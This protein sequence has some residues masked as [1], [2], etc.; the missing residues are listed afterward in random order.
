M[1]N[2]SACCCTADGW[3]VVCLLLALHL[4]TSAQ[5]FTYPKQMD[6]VYV[7]LE[8]TRIAFDAR[9]SLHNPVRFPFPTK[10]LTFADQ[11]QPKM[12]YS[13]PKGGTRNGVASGAVMGFFTGLAV[14]LILENRS[15][16]CHSIYCPRVAPGS[17]GFAL[18]ILGTLP[19]AIVG[20]IIGTRLRN[21]KVGD[22]SFR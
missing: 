4:H 10:A 6:E 12:K 18:G 3:L 9:A 15:G 19:G 5:G 20:G 11:P 17:T 1:K 22:T 7:T 14:G 8:P 21:K 2:I 16:T 13:R